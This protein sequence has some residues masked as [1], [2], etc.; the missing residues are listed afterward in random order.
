MPRQLRIEYPRAMHH[1]MSRGNCRQD[2]LLD[3][4]DLHDFFK[5]LAER[6]HLGTPKSAS[7][8]LVSSRKQERSSRYLQ[9]QLS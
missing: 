5:T 9:F 4:V 8:C 3:D 1:V 6:L 7:F 2:I